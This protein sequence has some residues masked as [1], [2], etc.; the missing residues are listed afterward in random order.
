MVRELGGGREEKEKTY[1]S[2]EKKH[3]SV[4]SFTGGEIGEEVEGEKTALGVTS[5]F[6][7]EKKR[8]RE[9]GCSTTYWI[10]KGKK[11]RK[12]KGS[13]YSPFYS[14]CEK[15]KRRE[16]EGGEWRV[17]TL[18]VTTTDR[19][20]KGGEGGRGPLITKGRGGGRASTVRFRCW[21]G[22]KKGDG[23]FPPQGRGEEGGPGHALPTAG[24][25]VKEKKKRDD[26]TFFSTRGR[27][28]GEER[29]IRCLEQHF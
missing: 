9:K 17:L 21:G 23:L 5:L 7:G 28:G 2:R 14:L 8:G 19:E 18:A 12:M 3:F 11:K 10:R 4:P 22:K 1:S 16:G 24:L 27:G 25:N 29:V 6:T 26:A 13:I 20:K 15:G